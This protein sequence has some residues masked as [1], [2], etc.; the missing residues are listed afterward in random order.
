ME[1]LKFEELCDQVNAAHNSLTRKD[2][3]SPSQHVLGMDVRL[4]GVIMTGE[5]NEVIE[6]AVLQGEK[7]FT[8]R[9][10]IRNAARAAF[11]KRRL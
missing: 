4:P 10:N 9:M 1:E 8:R 11:M 7:G 2:G 3:F 6:S 5:G